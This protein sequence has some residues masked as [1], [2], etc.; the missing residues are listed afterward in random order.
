[1]KTLFLKP[2][3]WFKLIIPAF[4]I[5]CF[6]G[7]N[8]DDDDDDGTV[9]ETLAASF[10][11]EIDENDFLSVQFSNF[12]RNTT[13]YEWDFGDG[14]SS[15][16][17]S[18]K[19]TYAE[20]GTYSVIL[21]AS[22]QYWSFGGVT[23]LGDRPCIL[24]DSYTFHRDGKFEA[25]TQGTVFVDAEANGGWKG[26]EGCFDES[27]SDA[28]IH[29][30]TGEDVSAFANG[31]DFTYTYE[32]DII[33]VNGLGN[34]IGLSSK[35]NAGDGYLPVETKTYE[36]FNFIDGNGIDSLQIAMVG[37]ISWN[38]YLVSYDNIADLPPIP[39]TKPR[40]AFDFTKDNL[41]VTFQNFSANAASYMWDFGDGGMSTERD[42]VYTY[43]ASGDYEVT[44]TVTDA[45]GASDMLTKTVSVSDVSFNAS[46]MSNA[47]GK[48]WRLAGEGSYKVGSSPGNGDFWGGPDAIVT[49]ERACQMDDEF[50]MNDDG[51]LSIKAGDEVW[52]EPYM[53]GTNT[54]LATADL[55]E[56]FNV[57]GGGT[58]SF[59]VIEGEPNQ[60]KVIGAGA[61]LGF[62]KPYNAGELTDDGLGMPAGEIIYD[63]FGFTSTDARDE[64]VLIID[65]VGDGCCYWTITLESLK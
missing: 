35:S 49:L 16:E 51:T 9:G 37:D 22:N 44:L 14:E 31:G 33:T 18:P 11:F 53:G 54:C 55:I 56:P 15:T 20:A 1:M 63:V 46:I 42:P 48:V 58:F 62:N 17:E 28:F 2:Q 30:S 7:C 61:Y 4:A 50:T 27:E 43:G 60:V 65:Y 41:S 45:D 10:Q 8:G 25:N 34:Y 52:A 29:F 6:M 39:T 13:S 19:H 24:D 21:T 38:F 57:Y 64:L 12:S 36:V 32:N 40:A 59:E 23:P 5:I 3:N 26:A 47:D